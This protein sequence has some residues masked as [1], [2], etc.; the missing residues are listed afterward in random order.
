MRYT[1]VFFLILLAFAF[2]SCQK[3]GDLNA[4]DLQPS[5]DV[6]FPNQTDTLTLVSQIVKEDTLG[7]DELSACLLGTYND[8]IFG[9]VICSFATQFT[10]SGS[11]PDFPTSYEVD[12][13]VLCLTYNG[14]AYGGLS[15]GTIQVK[16][17]SEPI[18]LD[19]SYNSGDT[20]PTYNE[21]LVLNPDQSYTF[22]PYN[23]FY[24][25]A[26]DSLLPQLRI[27]LKHDLGTRF[28]SP[29]NPAVLENDASFQ[30]YFHG[31]SVSPGIDPMGVA[32]FNLTN[33]NSKI[34]VYY[35]YDNNGVQD[36]TFY[37]FPITSECARFSKLKHFP[38][39][40]SQ[41]YLQNLLV[42]D[43]LDGSELTFIQAAAGVKTKLSLPNLLNFRTVEGRIVNKAEL[44][45][46]F[47]N[48]PH[49]PAPTVVFIF[50]KDANGVLQALPD[51]FNGVI[52]GS[53]ND[54][55]REY[56]LVITQ[57]IQKVLAGTI[58]NNDLYI[59]A[60]SAGVSVNR[61]VLHGPNFSSIPY[62]NMR[63]VLT[64]SN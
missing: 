33:I 13:V 58:E 45:I 7:T 32:A 51:Q 59:V 54:D 43:T 39:L 22:K 28:F 21:N 42:T 12:S 37:D 31:V 36:T 41:P 44:I 38:Q 63:L 20:P 57:Y 46:P 23:Y 10:L 49:L 24:S 61:V 50:Y 29:D 47:E 27:Q 6:L 56:R 48:D 11:N 1:Q 30:E 2:A 18:N 40:A 62:E 15:S 53:R 16:E 35:R 3:P 14:Y 26:T 34:A 55:T 5:E 4:G 19:S 25:S 9:K 64:L 17:L 52:G 8:E 60:G